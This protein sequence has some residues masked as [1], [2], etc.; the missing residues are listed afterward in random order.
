[1]DSDILGLLGLARKAGW[2]VMGDTPTTAAASRHHAK[3]ILVAADAAENT[4][5]KA[6]K[7][8]EMGN[9]PVFFVDCSKATLGYALGRQSCAVLAVTEIG[10]AATMAKKFARMDPDLYRPDAQLLDRRAKVTIRERKKPRDKN[11]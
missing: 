4:R 10:L 9:C 2:V 6:K 11:K 1:M 5:Q 7:V 8:G 3:L